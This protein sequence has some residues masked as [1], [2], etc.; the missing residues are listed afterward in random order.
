MQLI[1]LKDDKGLD[2][3]FLEEIAGG[4]WNKTQISRSVLSVNC[5]LKA[6]DDQGIISHS[7][8]LQRQMKSIGTNVALQ[9][10]LT[11]LGNDSERMIKYEASL[12]YAVRS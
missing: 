8:S 10:L 6:Y 12:G 3:G 2:T 7:K 1:S 5:T 9:W 4:Y 11:G